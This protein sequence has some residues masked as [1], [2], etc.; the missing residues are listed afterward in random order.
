MRVTALVVAVLCT[1]VVTLA[2]T[3]RSTVVSP[4]FYQSVLDEESAYDRVY[5]QV[6]VDPETAA[7]TRGLLARL[8]VPEAVITSNLKLVLPPETVRELTDTQID[9]VVG[10]LNGDRDSLA[11]KVDPRPVPANLDDLAHTYFGDLVS[12]V[13]RKA[14]PDFAAFSTDL[15]AALKALVAGHA[16]R[17]FPHCRFPSSRPSS[18]PTGSWTPYPRSNGRRCAPMSRWP[19]RPEMSPPRWPPWPPPW[20]PSRQQDAAARLRTAAGG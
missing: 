16:P 7:V 2:A 20:C 14:E 12:S 10:Y 18:R 17:R 8:P 11:L 6:L 9:A 15:N 1:A 19:W 5:D 3:A 13:Q 4:G